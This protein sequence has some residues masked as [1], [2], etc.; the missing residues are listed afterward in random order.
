M[1][2]Y[3][4][5]LRC[6]LLKFYIKPQLS[7]CIRSDTACCILLKFYIKPQQSDIS[8]N[9]TLSCILLKFYIKPQRVAVGRTGRAVVSY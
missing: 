9:L 2:E 5:A 8:Y 6:I 7:E 4:A 3:T 1:N